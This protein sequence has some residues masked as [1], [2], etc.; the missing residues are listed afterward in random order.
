MHFILKSRNVEAVQLTIEM[1]SNPPDWFKEALTSGVLQVT[2]TYAAT[3]FII[4]ASTS[5]DRIFSGDW[6]VSDET[7]ITLVSKDR[8]HDLYIEKPVMPE[9]YK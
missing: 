9:T 6:V 4:I 7:G 3:G 2:S 1:L 8:F 5:K